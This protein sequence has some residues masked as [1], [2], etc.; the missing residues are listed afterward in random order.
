VSETDE[1]GTEGQAEAPELETRV[2]RVE[3]KLDQLISIVSGKEQQGQKI[4]QRGRE[5]ELNAPTTVADQ[6]RAQLEERD[7]KAAETA[8]KQAETDRVA[9][10]EAKIAE[11]SEQPPE[12]PA[13]RVERF[14]GWR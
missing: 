8:G 2:D 9:A 4:A 13:R 14:M 3:S 11:M 10:L 5:A 1:T 6:I 12:T 7:R